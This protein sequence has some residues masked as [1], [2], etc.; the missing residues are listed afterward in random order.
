MIGDS[1]TLE[2]LIAIYEAMSKIKEIDRSE[3]FNLYYKEVEDRI[4]EPTSINITLQ[5]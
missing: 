2:N 5:K 3:Y 1:L 4:K